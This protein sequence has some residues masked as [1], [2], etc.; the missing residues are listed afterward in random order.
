M[1]DIYV[2]T[3]RKDYGPFS[4]QELQS[5]IRAGRVPLTAWLYQDEKWSLL[6]ETTGLAELHPDFEPKP[7]KP[8]VPKQA[9]KAEALPLTLASAALSQSTASTGGTVSAEPV[10][11]VI[12]DKKKSGPYSAADI[13]GQLQRKELMGSAFVWRPGFSTWQKLSQVTE[14]SRESMNRLAR[15]GTS[16]DILVKRKF[17]RAPYEVE[18]IAHDNTRAL[19]GKS[20]VIGEG[21]LFLSTPKPT[22]PIGARLKLHFR[23]GGAS[24]F[25]AVAEVVSIVR[26]H[27]PGYCLK[28]VALSDSDRKRIAKFVSER[29]TSS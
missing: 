29:R 20:M 24:A 28:F 12:R 2:R 25:N 1:D 27:M 23:E 22:H 9:K 17:A 3:Q 26:G 11:F 14:F 6:F 15:E 18:V 8:P 4:E 21:G 16:V 13:V 10:W 5:Q 7:E 19:E